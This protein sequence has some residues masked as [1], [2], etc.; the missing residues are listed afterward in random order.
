MSK[1][2]PKPE[3]IDKEKKVLELRRTGAGWEAIAEVVGFSNASGAYKAYQR[4]IARV[5]VQPAEELRT[6]ELDRLDRLQRAYWADAMA[7][8]VRAADFILRVIDKRCKI[9]GIEAPQRIQAEVITYDG[10]SIDADI[11]RIIRELDA[12]DQGLAVEVAQ[13][14]SQTRAITAAE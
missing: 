12:M 7:G 11:E 8:N 3:V 4:A 9:L 1:K 13:G 2:A 10:G 6:Q 5:L 14:V